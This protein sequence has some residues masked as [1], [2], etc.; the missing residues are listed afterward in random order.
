MTSAS[1]ESDLLILIVS[2]S[3]TLFS[4]APDESSLSDPA[5]STV[6]QYRLL[7]QVTGEMRS[8]KAMWQELP[9][10]GQRIWPT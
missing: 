3:R 8:I 1:A 7:S 10:L 4:P 5:K 9:R 6:H 2:F